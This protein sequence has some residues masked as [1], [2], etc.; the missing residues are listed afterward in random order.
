MEEAAGMTTIG[1]ISM[2]K[3]K[4]TTTMKMKKMT[5]PMHDTEKKRTMIMMR[6]K[7]RIMMMTRTKMKDAGETGHAMMTTKTRTAADRAGT[8]TGDPGN[9]KI[10]V[11]GEAVPVVMKTMTMEDHAAAP[12][13]PAAGHPEPGH[14][15][16]GHPE[17][18]HPEMDHPATD[19]PEMDHPEMG[20]PAMEV[21]E[22]GL[23]AWTANRLEGLR[24][25]ADGLLIREAAIPEIPDAGHPAG[26]A[27]VLIVQAA[28]AA[29]LATATPAVR[30]E[31]VTEAGV[32]AAQRVTPGAGHIKACLKFQELPVQAGGS[33]FSKI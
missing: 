32:R 2:T 9:R 21:R 24:P 30:D 14:P 3:R 10:R 22:E 23:P 5:G 15:E 26:Q 20:L 6:M 7:T 28:A 1:K 17:T 33:S 13:D 12:A 16:T 18:D 11:P 25:E 19:H 31:A 8:I 27:T 29:S 4:T